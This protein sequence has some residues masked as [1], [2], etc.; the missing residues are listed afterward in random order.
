MSRSSAAA[1]KLHHQACHLQN[2]KLKVSNLEV[3]YT[4]CLQK[5]KRHLCRKKNKNR[6]FENFKREKKNSVLSQRSQFCFL[7]FSLKLQTQGDIWASWGHVSTMEVSVCVVGGWGGMSRNSLQRLDR[8]R[9]GDADPLG[10]WGLRKA[11]A[12]RWNTGRSL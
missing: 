5:L 12:Q 2:I 4:C 7:F 3:D 6:L 1:S 9:R 10:F 8:F 11:P